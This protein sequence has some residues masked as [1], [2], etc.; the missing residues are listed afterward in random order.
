MYATCYH[1]LMSFYLCN[2]VPSFLRI[3]VI[4]LGPE[5]EGPFKYYCSMYIASV[6]L[7]FTG[8]VAHVTW[9]AVAVV[10]QVPGI[11]S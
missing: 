4:P 10:Y 3:S 1:V 7:T 2:F 9:Y 6:F 8:I 5:M 11:H